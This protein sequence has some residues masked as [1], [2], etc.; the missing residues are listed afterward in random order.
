MSS[1]AIILH[2]SPDYRYVF[3]WQGQK[4]PVVNMFDMFNDETRD[5]TRCRKIVCFMAP[6]KWLSCPV[7]PGELQERD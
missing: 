5:P 7:Y 1:D 2:Y 6:G 4:L 3:E